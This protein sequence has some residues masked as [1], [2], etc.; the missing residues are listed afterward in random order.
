MLLAL[1][2]VLLP[3]LCIT[4]MLSERV[5]LEN[6][7]SFSLVAPLLLAKKQREILKDGKAA[8]ELLLPEYVE[9]VWAVLWGLPC[10][11]LCAAGVVWGSEGRCSLGN[12]LSCGQTVSFNKCLV[13]SV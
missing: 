10:C 4:L 13:S 3:S 1:W 6:F 5:S 7:L 8:P 2:Q 12:S 11:Q 9:D